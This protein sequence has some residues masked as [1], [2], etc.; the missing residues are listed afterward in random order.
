MTEMI[1][2]TE[3]NARTLKRYGLEAV[4]FGVGWLLVDRNGNA[5]AMA[6]GALV[7]NTEREALDEGARRVQQGRC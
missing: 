5:L 4:R 6:N 7:A 3:T 1:E 2:T